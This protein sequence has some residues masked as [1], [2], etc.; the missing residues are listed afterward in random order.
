MARRYLRFLPLALIGGALVAIIASGVLSELTLDAFEARRAALD[1]YVAAHRHEAL[2]IYIAI[3]VA[4]MTLS[5]PAAFVLSVTGGY[6]FGVMLGAPVIVFAAT[7]G[8]TLFYLACRTAL[9]DF[10]RRHTQGRLA[11]LEDGLRRNAFTYILMLRLTPAAPLFIV[12][13]AAGLLDV[14][15]RDFVLATALGLIPV[16]VVCASVGVGLRAT[17]AA[18]GAADPVGAMQRLFL[19]PQVLVPIIGLALLGSLPLLL[20]RFRRAPVPTDA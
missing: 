13:L 16:S 1:A 4:A 12:N 19:S 10:L 15:A 2:A 6:L 18:G 20:R 7:L 17:L 8:S 9:G 5:L 11:Q 14:R 3:Y